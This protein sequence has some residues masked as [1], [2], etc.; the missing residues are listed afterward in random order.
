MATG[1]PRDA[2]P[3]EIPLSA[4]L[5]AALADADRVPVRLGDLVDRTADRGFGLLLLVLGLPMLVPFLP[6]GSST[7][8]GPIYAVCAVQMLRG[9]PRPWMPRRFRDWVLSPAAARAL[10]D[11]GV[12]IVR[13]LERLSR[14]RGLWVNERVA[15]RVAGVMV[16]LMGVVLL[17]PLPLLNTLPAL[18]VMLIG[19]G[20]LNRDAVF[21]VAGLLAGATALALVGLSVG[22]IVTLLGRLRSVP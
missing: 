20:L 12:P 22:L 19:V 7:V 5:L 11:R 13:R 1:A 17:S 16:L 4:V 6:P 9:T 3:R 15:M 21:M 10:R 8:V 18:A 14:P 2:P